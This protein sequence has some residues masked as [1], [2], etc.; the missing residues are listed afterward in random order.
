MRCQ[1]SKM[2]FIDLVGQRFV[3]ELKIEAQWEVPELAEVV[4]RLKEA[5]KDE[6]AFR[7]M[8]DEEASDDDESGR[9]VRRDQAKVG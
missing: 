8:V 3:C 1:C 6:E 7:L 2:I 9:L 4:D 5:H